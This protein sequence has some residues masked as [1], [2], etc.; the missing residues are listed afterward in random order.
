MRAA[1]PPPLPA[2]QEH[3]LDI[4]SDCYGELQS[5]RADMLAKGLASVPETIFTNQV[6]QALARKLPSNI[7][8][9]CA[10][11]GVTDEKYNA[12]GPKF[13][14]VTK[15]YAQKSVEANGVMTAGAVR[16]ARSGYF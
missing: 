10:V 15:K 8:E 13:L 14:E 3:D 6:L 5:V 11:P 12:F 2:A 16:G 1:A 9:F 4:V 7:V